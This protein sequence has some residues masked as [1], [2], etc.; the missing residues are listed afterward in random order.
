MLLTSN[1]LDRYNRGRL[2]FVDD[3]SV[4]PMDEGNWLRDEDGDV[5]AG[6]PTFALFWNT[7]PRADEDLVANIQGMRI[8]FTG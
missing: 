3:D 7:P 6:I 1:G 2:A 8:I 5:P 4:R